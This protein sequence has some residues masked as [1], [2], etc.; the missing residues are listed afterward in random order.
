MAAGR[1]LRVVSPAAALVL[2]GV[3]LALMIADV[4]LASLARQSL[5]AS[6]GSAP[7]IRRRS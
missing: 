5:D 3:L 1:R 2:A 4:P 6:G 7:R